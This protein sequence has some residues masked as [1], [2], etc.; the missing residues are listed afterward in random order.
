MASMMSFCWELSIF[1]PATPLSDLMNSTNS[2]LSTDPSPFRSHIVN[3]RVNFCLVPPKLLFIYN[4]FF[5]T[6]LKFPNHIKKFTESDRIWVS[7]GCCSKHSLNKEIVFSHSNRVGKFAPKRIENLVNNSF[8][9]DRIKSFPRTL[10]RSMNT[11]L[12]FSP[13]LAH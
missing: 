5:F 10:C 4:E 2:S 11:N 13:Q 3:N 9:E 8:I 7:F 6:S 12:T 1:T